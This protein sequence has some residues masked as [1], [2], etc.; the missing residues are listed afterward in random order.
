MQALHIQLIAIFSG[1]SG[2]GCVSSKGRSV[3]DCIR[4][5][6]V[7]LVNF[8]SS[9]HGRQFYVFRQSQA[10]RIYCDRAQSSRLHVFLRYSGWKYGWRHVGEYREVIQPFGTH[11]SNRVSPNL[12]DLLPSCPTMSKHSHDLTPSVW[13]LIGLQFM[14]WLIFPASSRVGFQWCGFTLEKPLND[15]G[16]TS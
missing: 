11:P 3:F 9:R 2:R 7:N 12:D 4:G 5:T 8:G 14:A 15:S 6:T 10:R 1:L 13:H 16:S